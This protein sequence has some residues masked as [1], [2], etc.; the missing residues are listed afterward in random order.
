MFHASF[1]IKEDERM[2]DGQYIVLDIEFTKSRDKTEIIQIGAQRLLSYDYGA[3]I[4]EGDSFNKLVKPLQLPN[5][6]LLNL[7]G[8][9]KEDLQDAQSFEKVFQD[10]LAW[11]GKEETFYVVWGTRDSKVIRKECYNYGFIN[12]FQRMDFIDIQSYTM[13]QKK[14]KTLPS[15]KSMVRK[16]DEFEGKQHDALSDAINTSKILKNII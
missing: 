9:K 16:Y 15:L 10:F 2:L 13:L 8:I 6:S 3:K 1:L 7:L 12:E 4:E 14:I 5:K 11:V